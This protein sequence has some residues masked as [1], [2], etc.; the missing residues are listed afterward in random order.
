MNRNLINGAIIILLLVVIW[1]FWK[2]YEQEQQKIELNKE[3]EIKEQLEKDENIELAKSKYYQL[4]LA[5]Y[6]KIYSSIEIRYLNWKMDYKVI[7]WARDSKENVDENFVNAINLNG[8]T[9][10]D[11][12]FTDVDKFEVFKVTVDSDEL[13]TSLWKNPWI[14]EYSYN[15]SKPIDKETYKRIDTLNITHTIPIIL[16]T[17]GN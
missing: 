14:Y 9:Y 15:G 3:R 10:I 5:W 4:E 13:I 16:S 2:F 6:N 17:E 8:K 7:I 1:F 12:N 11:Y